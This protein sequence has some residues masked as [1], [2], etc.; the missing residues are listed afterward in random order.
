[1]KCVGCS[2]KNSIKLNLIE[3]FICSHC[4]TEIDIT[5]FQHENLPNR[6]REKGKKSTKFALPM[7]LT[8]SIQ[9]FDGMSKIWPVLYHQRVTQFE[10]EKTASKNL[11]K[12][13]F[14]S[15]IFLNLFDRSV[16][17]TFFFIREKLKKEEEEKDRPQ[18]L[19]M[20]VSVKAQEMFVFTFDERKC[21]DPHTHART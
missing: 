5:D 14:N 12:E 18:C 16:D 13:N 20:D 3:I 1:M 17:A 6:R 10:K 15:C 19:T 8:I 4:F 11:L 9:L 21:P 2:Y 7:G